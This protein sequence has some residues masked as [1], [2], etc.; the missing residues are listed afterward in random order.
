[1]GLLA[2]AGVIYQT[3]CQNPERVT[4]HLGKLYKGLKTGGDFLV[5]L[6]PFLCLSGF[7][8]AASMWFQEAWDRVSVF[9]MICFSTLFVAAMCLRKISSIGANLHIMS[10][11]QHKASQQQLFTQ[12]NMLRM[13]SLTISPEFD[14]KNRE[15]TI[16]FLDGAAASIRKNSPEI[17]DSIKKDLTQP[18]H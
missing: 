3:Y 1:M 4:G 16:K 17:F 7:I 15:D 10:V 9:A 6:L 5:R 18:N 11:Q 13:F 2:F 14:E 12:Y 8:C